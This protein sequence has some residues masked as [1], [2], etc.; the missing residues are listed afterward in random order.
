MEAAKRE[1]KRKLVEQSKK[2]MLMIYQEEDMSLEQRIEKNKRA[3]RRKLVAR[4]KIIVQNVANLYAK[5]MSQMQEKAEEK[6]S[7]KARLLGE[8][9]YLRTKTRVD[10]NLQKSRKFYIVVFRPKMR[11]NLSRVLPKFF[12]FGLTFF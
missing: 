12:I 11:N 3:R 2:N 9:H 5:R 4:F 6:F 1:Q 8:F 7:A 10:W